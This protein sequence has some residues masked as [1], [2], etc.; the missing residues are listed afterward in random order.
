MTFDQ[1]TFPDFQLFNKPI[2]SI[3][4][5]QIFNATESVAPAIAIKCKRL[6][7]LHVNACEFQ[8]TPADILDAQC[9]PTYWAASCSQLT[10][11]EVLWYT[12]VLHGSHCVL[13]WAFNFTGLRRLKSVFLHI[14]N[15]F[16]LAIGCCFLPVSRTFL[17][18]YPT[19]PRLRVQRRVLR[20]KGIVCLYES[21]SVV[22]HVALSVSISAMLLLAENDSFWLVKLITF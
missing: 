18:T 7:S 8:V 9:W 21:V 10:I 17:A 4:P 5:P 19:L 3:P 11:Q 13:V 2:W 22:I 15:S 14:G 1:C 16:F 20:Q 6:P 12:A